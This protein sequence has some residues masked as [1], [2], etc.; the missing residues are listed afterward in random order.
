MNTFGSAKSKIN[1]SRILWGMGFFDETEY[2]RETP[3]LSSVASVVSDAVGGVFEAVL[4]LGKDIQGAESQ[5]ESKGSGKFPTT[6]S[7]EFNNGVKVE[8]LQKEKEDREEADKKK[9]FY[10]ALKE[11][12]ERA[13]RAKDKLLFEEEISDIATNLPTD[14]KN[15]L[16]HYQASYKDRSI[17]QRAELR[18]KLIEERKNSEKKQ[19]EDSIKATSKG[20]LQMGENELLKGGEN[21]GHFTKA[22]G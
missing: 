6:G 15:Q 3:I 4:D 1:P 20:S 17:Y 21:F 8:E 9:A 5:K 22:V 16:L 19:Q 12:E 10:Q 13:R 11:D 2:E 7:I 14:Q 18:K